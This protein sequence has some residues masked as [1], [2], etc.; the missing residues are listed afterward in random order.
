[1]RPLIRNL[2]L[3]QF[4]Q[5]DEGLLPA[6]VAHLR[7]NGGGQSF[8]L[9]V[10]FRAAGDLFQINGRF[11]FSRQVWVVKFVGVTDAAMRRQLAIF[12]TEGMSRAG[13][14]VGE[15]HFEGAADSCLQVVHLAGESV[16]RKPFGLGIRIKES[17]VDLLGRRADDTMK[18]D[19]VRGHGEWI[20]TADY[21]DATDAQPK[22]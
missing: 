1:M 8:L 11:D 9:D 7:R 14:E 2:G 16:R 15:R 13:A 22:S 17:P 3:D 5:E 18:S 10:Q 4:G 21:A 19:G 20:L 6:E 12:S